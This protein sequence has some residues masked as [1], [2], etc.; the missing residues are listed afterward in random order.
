MSP[1]ARG[2]YEVLADAA[3]VHH[4]TGTA[5]CVGLP[6]PCDATADYADIA[7]HAT[8]L[9]LTV[10]SLYVT[11]GSRGGTACDL[12]HPQRM[13][14]QQALDNLMNAVKAADELGVERMVVRLGSE[15]RY[16]GLAEMQAR[17]ER[18]V[19][20][21]RAVYQQLPPGT[22]LAVE[23]FS[24]GTRHW[25]G[26]ALWRHTLA[27]CEQ[28]GDNAGLLVDTSID[29]ND[30]APPLA[31]LAICDR[32]AGLIVA[33][34]IQG[35]VE[36]SAVPS[37]RFGVFSTLA[38][39]FSSGVVGP[40]LLVTLAS[41]VNQQPGVVGLMESVL[42]IQHLSVQVSQAD[43]AQLRQA[44][45]SDLD[46]EQS[47]GAL[48]DGCEREVSAELFALRHRLGVDSEPIA[49][50]DRAIRARYQL[51]ERRASMQ[52]SAERR[53]ATRRPER[54]GRAGA[55][56]YP[57]GSGAPSGASHARAVSPATLDT[58]T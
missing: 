8:E 5:P 45:Q 43:P 39:A 13:V 53:L 58:T 36:A 38:D 30:D 12:S 21:L 15:A 22:S 24:T 32:L 52:R 7:C 11:V 40:E 49:A 51:T 14:R 19:S 57:S 25:E 23:E 56:R 37:S 10:S 20:A 9:G 33:G 34:P 44:L 1:V 47:V 28:L 31:E 17:D 16:A 48:L 46:D 18:L 42:A 2:P 54:R 6:F 26:E 4:F 35:C 29:Y 27:L 50:Y 41:G 3:V 55:S